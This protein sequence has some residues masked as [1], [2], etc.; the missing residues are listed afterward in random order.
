MLAKKIRWTL[1]SLTLLT[2]VSW[3]REPFD[4]LAK[5][6]DTHETEVRQ[7]VSESAD[8]LP[9]AYVK[10]VEKTFQQ[11]T[12]L[13]IEI[14]HA[15]L[16]LEEQKSLIAN[17]SESNGR[18]FVHLNKG[19]DD[20]M[21]VNSGRSTGSKFQDA[22][23]KVGAFIKF[24]FISMGRDVM[25][26]VPGGPGNSIFNDARRSGLTKDMVQTIEKALASQ[27]KAVTDGLGDKRSAGVAALVAMLEGMK[28]A[29]SL[30][31]GRA[32]LSMS[33]VYVGL[34]AVFFLNPFE[35]FYKT[36][37]SPMI[38]GL[39]EMIAFWVGGAVNRYF[40]SGVGGYRLWSKLFKRS[41]QIAKGH[42]LCSTPLVRVEAPR[43]R[44]RVVR[45][46]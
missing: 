38:F 41:Q 35:F 21:T 9:S 40:N 27:T 42:P 1:A 20:V 19:F 45:I 29:E 34:G 46:D 15:D 10:N 39:A 16:E 26:V 31:W 18:L 13:L 23:Q 8:S 44:G 14:A 33:L 28:D 4:S 24:S 2:S 11:G 25:A 5:R 3:A 6:V 36:A 37:S 17:L 32:N 7:L 30:R 22:L 43:F 12:D